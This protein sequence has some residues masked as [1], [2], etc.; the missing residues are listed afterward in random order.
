MA[1]LEQYYFELQTP[2]M[3]ALQIAKWIIVW[4][5]IHFADLVKDAKSVAGF[6]PSRQLIVGRNDVT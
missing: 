5:K 1:A 3:R 2:K 4:K 6:F